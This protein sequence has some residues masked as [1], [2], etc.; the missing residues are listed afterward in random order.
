MSLILRACSLILLATTAWAGVPWLATAPGSTGSCG[1]AG[2]DTC[3]PTTNVL[4]TYPPAALAVVPGGIGMSLVAGDVVSS[5]SFASSSYLTSKVYF[6]VTPG[7][8]GL[9]GSAVNSEATAGEAA[10]DVFFAGTLGVPVPNVGFI[11]GD[12]LPAAAAP[13]LG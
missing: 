6:S 1:V 9:P 3:Q 10:A 11:D 8:V 13:A 4:T 2:L 5:L 12:G 7:S